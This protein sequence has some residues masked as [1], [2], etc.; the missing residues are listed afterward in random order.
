MTDAAASGAPVPSG[1]LVVSQDAARGRDQVRLAQVLRYLADRGT[2]VE[3]FLW[4][5]G[6]LLDDLAASC[7][8]VHV[9][10][11]MHGWRPARILQAAGRH[12]A[13]DRLKGLRLRAHLRRRSR[14]LPVVYLHGA[15]AGRMLGYLDG[16]RPVVAHLHDL[17]EGPDPLAGLLEA[18]D[19]ELLLARIDAAVV[20]SPSLEPVVAQQAGLAP[21]RV[22]VRREY[23]DTS[24]GRDQLGVPP[25]AAVV[26]AAGTEDWWRA[27]D[28]IVPIVWQV[29][30]RAETDVR[31]VWCCRHDEPEAL[32][33]LRHDLAAA[34]LEHR[35]QIL[36]TAAA[37]DVLVLADV[38]LAVGRRGDL[39][40]LADDLRFAGRPVVASDESG[41]AERLPGQAVEVPYLDLAAAV[42]AVLDVLGSGSGGR[43]PAPEAARWTGAGQLLADVGTLAALGRRPPP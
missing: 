25:D 36:P 38:V 5:G 26:V 1:L 7:R 39:V 34:G 21:E 43:A 28:P 18:P 30:R 42:D 14:R 16:A 12:R 4:E 20:P 13:A 35:A 11:E 9:V 27:P 41:L 31:L 40:P 17:A 15:V 10:E 23:G 32:W 24:V 3:L 22:R 8:A 29:A 6:P 37:V 2:S 33:P 19:A